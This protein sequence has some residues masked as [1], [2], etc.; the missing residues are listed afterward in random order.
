MGGKSIVNAFGQETDFCTCVKQGWELFISY[1]DC[2][3]RAIGVGA[4]AWSLSTADDCHQGFPHFGDKVAAVGG[5]G[6]AGAIPLPQFPEV[7]KS[8]SKE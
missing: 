6:R 5:N 7:P 8:C 2:E 4:G 1:R 3:G